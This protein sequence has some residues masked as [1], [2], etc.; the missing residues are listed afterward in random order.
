MEKKS[1]KVLW[2]YPI[3]GL[4]FLITFGYKIETMTNGSGLGLMAVIVLLLILAVNFVTVMSAA[5]NVIREIK[6]KSTRKRG[7][8]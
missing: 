6:G 4:F 2:L 5:G 3:V 7:I 8:K 1:S